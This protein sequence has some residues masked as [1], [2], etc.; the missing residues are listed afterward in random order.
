M[1]YQKIKHYAV[2]SLITFMTGFLT[3]LIPSID[4]I[5]LQSFEVSALIGL[6]LVAMRAGVKALLE[7][8]LQKLMKM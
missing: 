8:Y 6:F 3:M 1:N 4:K 7:K 2:S 5:S